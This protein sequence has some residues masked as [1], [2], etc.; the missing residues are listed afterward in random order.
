MA[1]RYCVGIAVVLRR[2][3]FGPASALKI[4]LFYFE[5]ERQSGVLIFLHRSAVAPAARFGSAVSQAG[6]SKAL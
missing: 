4:L 2:C 1:C 3:D 6:A 5:S